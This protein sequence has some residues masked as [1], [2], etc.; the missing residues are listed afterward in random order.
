VHGPPG[1]TYPELAA[2]AR[3][4]ASRMGEISFLTEIDTSLEEGRERLEVLV[5]RPKAALHGIALEAVAE[6]VRLT[7]SNAIIGGLRRA[8]G[9]EPTLIR[10]HV[11]DRVRADESVLRTLRVGSI[12]GASVPLGELVR[13]ERTPVEQPVQRKNRQR[14]VYVTAESSGTP[15]AEA[16]LRI[17]DDLSRDLPEGLRLEWRGDGEWKVTMDS[18]SDLGRAFAFSLAAIYVLLVAQTGSLALPGVIMLAIPLTMIGVFPGFW[19]LNAL[20]AG[21]IAGI[22]DP[23]FFSGP[24]L[25]GLIALAGIVVRN[26]IILIDFIDVLRARGFELHDAIIE[27]TVTRLRP[28]LLTAGA[29]LLGAW[30]IVLDPIFSGLAWAIVF[31]LVSST[32]LTLA[33]VPISYARLATR[34]SRSP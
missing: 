19:L 22:V 29:A 23:V 21:E 24:A 4:V 10:F 16:V 31:G 8:H 25:M 9:R 3:L 34:T 33:V 14:V 6:T 18:L 26:S 7:F 32:A 20:F 12:S 2:V 15:P 28:I 5:D 27:A 17:H 1:A 30:I 11:P 13:F